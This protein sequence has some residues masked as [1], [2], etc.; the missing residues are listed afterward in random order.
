MT[1]SYRVSVSRFGD[2]MC[3]FYVDGRADTDERGTD[4]TGL[5]IYATRAKAEAAGKRY[6]KKMQKN[7]FETF[8]I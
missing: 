1:A 2:W 3:H 6:L 4:G 8:K 5:K 7:G